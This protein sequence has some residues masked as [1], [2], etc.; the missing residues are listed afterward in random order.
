MEFEV[1]KTSELK[2]YRRVDGKLDIRRFVV[3]S[4]SGDKYGDIMGKL[5]RAY[6]VD[7]NGIK[8]YWKGK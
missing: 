5:I 6:K 2:A 7:P 4:S 3:V 8:V 1:V